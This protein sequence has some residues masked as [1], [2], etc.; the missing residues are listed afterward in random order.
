MRLLASALVAST[1]ALLSCSS[2]ATDDTASVTQTIGPDGGTI[3]VGGATVTFPQGAL[4]LARD[5]TITRGKANPPAGYTALSPVFQ[6]QPSGIDFAAPV[7]MAMPFTDDGKGP[8]TMFWSS[9]SQ[10]AFADVGGTAANG[11]MTAN[12]QHFSSGFVGR[13]P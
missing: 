12:V 8:A 2:D 4:V 6:C 7:T 13:K 3:N 9:G 5:I 1:F 10:P 11:I